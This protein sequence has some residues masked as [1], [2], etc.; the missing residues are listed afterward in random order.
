[1]GTSRQEPDVL[2]VSDASERRFRFFRAAFIAQAILLL[3]VVAVMSFV[4]WR[5]DAKQRSL[6]NDNIKRAKD[7]Q[8]AQSDFVVLATQAAFQ[9]RSANRP[10]LA[11]KELENALYCDRGSWLAWRDEAQAMIGEHRAQ[12]TLDAMQKA[13]IDKADGRNLLTE[14]M[15]QCAAGQ[16][17]TAMQLE[18]QAQSSSNKPSPA[19]L[20]DLNS[21]CH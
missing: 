6:I 17:A 11:D 12:Q 9:L 15:L 5:F 2:R 13:P 7:L 21:I 3:L 16:R 20:S 8:Q 18:S 19:E 4:S 14:A 10:D 1:M